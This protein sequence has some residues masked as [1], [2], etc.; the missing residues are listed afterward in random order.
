MFQTVCQQWGY[1]KCLADKVKRGT[2]YMQRQT[3]CASPCEQSSFCGVSVWEQCWSPP[4]LRKYIFRVL[5]WVPM[6]LG[7]TDPLSFLHLV[8]QWRVGSDPLLHL[9]VLTPRSLSPFYSCPSSQQSSFVN[10]KHPLK[11]EQKESIY[12]A[13]WLFP[14]PRISNVFMFLHWAEPA[15]FQSTSNGK[16]WVE[17]ECTKFLIFKWQLI[18]PGMLMGMMAWLLRGSSG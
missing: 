15:L 7:N 11:D 14:G 8:G 12:W 4:G 13:A 9:L 1:H 5:P 2:P 16:G 17:G 6:C 18:M 3:M 10:D